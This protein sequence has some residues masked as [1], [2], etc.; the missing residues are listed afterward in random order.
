MFR[1]DRGL[2]LLLAAEVIFLAYFY[3][4]WLSGQATF[5]YSDLSYYF[6]PL[7]KYV[8]DNL[9]QGHLPLW[10][11]YLYCGMPQIA[12]LSPS[13]LYP[14]GIL[15]TLLPFSQAL[16]AY[17][18]FHQLISAL[19]GYLLGRNLGHGRLAAFVLGL[20]F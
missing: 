16:A 15:F 1:L 5:Y 17:M 13:F 6:E 8:A 2:V 12:V 3:F 11:P 4:P 7:C 19:G 18:I 9:R 10:N 20:S 14:P